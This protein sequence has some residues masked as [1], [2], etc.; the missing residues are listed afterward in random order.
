[1]DRLARAQFPGGILISYRPRPEDM[2]LLTEQ[3]FQA[4]ADG[5]ETLFQTP[6][7]VNDLH[8]K[9]DIFTQTAVFPFSP[10]N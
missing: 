9:A 7:H 8:I 4:F 1:V 6:F 10:A 2:A 3:A 5:A